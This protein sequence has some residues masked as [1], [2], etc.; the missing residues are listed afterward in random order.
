MKKVAIV[1]TKGGV[2]KTTITVGLARALALTGHTTGILDADFTAPNI[3]VALKSENSKP[4]LIKNSI[5]LP[6][7]IDGIPFLSWGMI[8][9]A[10]SAVL[11]DDRQISEDDLYFAVNLIRSE[12]YREAEK[13]LVWL[14]ENPSGSCQLMRTLLADGA[15][16]WGNMEYLLIDTPPTTSGSIKEVIT[17]DLYGVVLITQPSR[18]SLADISRSLDL[19]RKRRVGIIGI[20]CNMIDCTFD[21]A[22]SDIITF[23]AFQQVQYLGGVPMCT[24]GNILPYCIPIAEKVLSL[25]PQT[26]PEKERSEDWK[27]VAQTA[28]QMSRLLGALKRKP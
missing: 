27:I 12:K 7:R 8:W 10:D 3:P 26:L 14:A 18:L 13:Y 1:S 5:I 6:P 16:E 9:P 4:T 24:E 17:A 11:I 23:S 2:G 25:T 15:V 28:S 21:L 19:L 22:E 20:V